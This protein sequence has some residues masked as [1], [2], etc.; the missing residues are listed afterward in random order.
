M[1]LLSHLKVGFRHHDTYP[2]RLDKQPPQ[3][4]PSDSTPA[5][6][7]RGKR[8]L[9]ISNG[10][11]LF[12]FHKSL[13]NV[14]YSFKMVSSDIAF[15]FHVSFSLKSIWLRIVLLPF[16]LAM[17]VSASHCC[18]FFLKSTPIVSSPISKIIW[19]FPAG[20]VTTLGQNVV[21]LVG[22]LIVSYQKVGNE[23]PSRCYIWSLCSHLTNPTVNKSIFSNHLYVR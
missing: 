5:L 19:L 18:D 7:H 20:Q 6:S 17:F 1:P 22:V 12:K 21:Q 16:C 3:R 4:T 13:Q 9:T 23:R 11:P 15:G 8:A 2:K 10:Q 14:V